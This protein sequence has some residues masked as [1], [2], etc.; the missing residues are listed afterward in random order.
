MIDG[1]WQAS[2]SGG[3]PAHGVP[4]KMVWAYKQTQFVEMRR[5]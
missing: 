4:D 1:D 2:Y 5:T 3:D